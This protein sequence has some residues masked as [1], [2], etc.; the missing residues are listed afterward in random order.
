MELMIMKCASSD[1]RIQ[2][3]PC[4][5]SCT[6]PTGSGPAAGAC[7]ELVRRVAARGAGGAPGWWHEEFFAL[8]RRPEREVREGARMSLSDHVL[9]LYDWITMTAVAALGGLAGGHARCVGRVLE[10]LGQE[11]E[12]VAHR[13]R[14]VS[15]LIR[16]HGVRCCCL[17]DLTADTLRAVMGALALDPR[18]GAYAVAASDFNPSGK[19]G[20]AIIVERAAGV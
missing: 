8:W 5:K 3:R 2:L 16:Q 19:H 11:P 12:P 13:A 10:L 4:P 18:G 14:A 15:E 9:R 1:K 20:V 6:P 7:L 17:T